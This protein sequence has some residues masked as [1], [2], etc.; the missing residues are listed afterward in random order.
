MSPSLD[1]RDLGAC[2]SVDSASEGQRSPVL[3]E[4]FL[5]SAGPRA[6]SGAVGHLLV[7]L[8]PN[9]LLQLQDFLKGHGGQLWNR[10]GRSEDRSNQGTS[11]RGHGLDHSVD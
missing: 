7:G 11:S 2:G 10:G 1:P 4:A 8:H 5:S 3:V 6:D 9:L